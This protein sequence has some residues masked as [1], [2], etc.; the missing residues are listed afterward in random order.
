M[1]NKYKLDCVLRLVNFIINGRHNCFFHLLMLIRMVQT[2]RLGNWGLLKT[3]SI[4]VSFE[5][6]H[7]ERCISRRSC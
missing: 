3:V 4:M 1:E 2:K 6:T 5:R 7:L